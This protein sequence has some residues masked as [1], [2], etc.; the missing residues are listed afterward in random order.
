MA[1]AGGQDMLDRE[2][3]EKMFYSARD[4]PAACLHRMFSARRLQP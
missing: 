4:L 1:K 3:A 2:H